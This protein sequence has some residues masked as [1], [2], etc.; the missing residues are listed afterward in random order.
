MTALLRKIFW[1]FLFLAST[2]GFYVVFEHGL[3]NFPENAKKEYE[4]AKKFY[5]EK[6]EKKE[7]S[8]EA[9]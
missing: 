8:K 4:N 5:H 2:F 7:D 9:P 6:V 1:F 3:E